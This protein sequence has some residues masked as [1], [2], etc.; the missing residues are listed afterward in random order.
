MKLA[1]LNGSRVIFFSPLQHGGSLRTKR[2]GRCARPLSSKEPIHIVFKINS[3]SLPL[4]LRHR[5][6]FMKVNSLIEKYSQKFAIRV[7]QCSIQNDHIH[8]LIRASRRQFF[9]SFFRVLAGQIAQQLMKG[10]DTHQAKE[11][12]FGETKKSLW[13]YRPFTRVVRGFKAYKIVRDYIQLNEKEVLK[14]IKYQAQRL[15]GLS[16]SDWKILWS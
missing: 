16:S 15:K 13:K 7:E 14:Q 8:L 9:Q 5:L 11:N 1:S 10:T 12:E 2:S 6:H 4:G 3:K